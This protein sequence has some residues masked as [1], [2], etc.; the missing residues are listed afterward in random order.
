MGSFKEMLSDL[1]IWN[2]IAYL[3]NEAKN[4]DIRNN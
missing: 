4:E 1:E 2:I 3:R